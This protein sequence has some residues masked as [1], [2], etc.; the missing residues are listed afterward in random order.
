VALPAGSYIFRAESNSG[1]AAGSGLVVSVIDGSLTPV[2]IPI[3]RAPVEPYGGS[4]AFPDPGQAPASSHACLDQAARL[5]A[6]PIH[7]DRG[8]QAHP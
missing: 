5:R 7:P 6:L 3:V 2:C 8:D 4:P 1:M